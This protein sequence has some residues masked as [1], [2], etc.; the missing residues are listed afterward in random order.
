MNFLDS[1]V[2]QRN[3][4]K[5]YGKSSRWGLMFFPR[6]LTGPFPFRGFMLLETF[7]LKWRL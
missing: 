6:R 2:P 4:A 3:A 1:P 7:F 5:F